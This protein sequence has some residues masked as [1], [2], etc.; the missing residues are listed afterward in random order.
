MVISQLPGCLC[1]ALEW[2]G[3][4]H[5]GY[6][7]ASEF[8]AGVLELGRCENGQS[9][10]PHHG[11]I[12]LLGYPR[13]LN[14]AHSHQ[15]LLAD[16]FWDIE[17][18]PTVILRPMVQCKWT[19]QYSHF[20]RIHQMLSVMVGITYFVLVIIKRWLR[21]N[22]SHEIL[23]TCYIRLSITIFGKL[24]VVVMLGWMQV[25]RNFTHALNRYFNLAHNKAA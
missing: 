10:Y 8:V 4:P 13:C 18:H 21:I 17:K 3:N 20:S 11:L 14:E 7:S 15:P 23:V 19:H 16:A 25:F 24:S 22:S 5:E 2:C 9:W 12:W 6:P 1:F